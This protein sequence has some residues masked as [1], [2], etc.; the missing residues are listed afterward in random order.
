VDCSPPSGSQFPLG[1]TTVTCFATD[2]A[3]NA[4]SCSFTVTLFNVCVQDDIKRDTL[5]FNSQTGDYLFVKCGVGSLSRSGRGISR[6]MGGVITLEHN[7]SDRRVFA[8]IDNSQKKGTASVQTFSPSTT[9]TITD[10]N[11]ADDTCACPR[12]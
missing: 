3:N 4:S 7:V 12:E 2:T 1:A 8:K 10:R 11:T 5:L 6:V 9:H